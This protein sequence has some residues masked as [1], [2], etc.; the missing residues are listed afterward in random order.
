[1]ITQTISHH[2]V[3]W[4]KQRKNSINNN[5][6]KTNQL[7]MSIIKNGPNK[8]FLRNFIRFS[9]PPKHQMPGFRF[10]SHICLCHNFS[11]HSFRKTDDKIPDA[12]NDNRI[13][14]LTFLFGPPPKMMI[15]FLTSLSFSVTPPK[16]MIGFLTSLS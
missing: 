12:K 5:K 8:F 14:D 1:M 6:T 4:R 2:S 10:I 11:N 15:V 7:M 16:M 13:P 3:F 9:V